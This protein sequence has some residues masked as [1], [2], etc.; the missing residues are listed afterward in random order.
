[1]I[2]F[3][4]FLHHWILQLD[5]KEGQAFEGE[6]LEELIRRLRDTL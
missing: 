1:M 2:A 6:L 5:Y 4:N 3:Y